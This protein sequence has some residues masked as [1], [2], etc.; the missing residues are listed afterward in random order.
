MYW[1]TSPLFGVWS[2][3][4]KRTLRISCAT[5]IISTGKG[6]D[7]LP[8]ISVDCPPQGAETRW[9][10]STGPEGEK[11]GWSSTGALC[12]TYL[13]SIF[14]I[15]LWCSFWPLCVFVNRFKSFSWKV[16]MENDF[17]R[18]LQGK[19]DLF[20]VSLFLLPGIMLFEDNSLTVWEFTS[21]L[22]C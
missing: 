4:K 1:L 15:L 3:K 2:G 5:F 16:P 7:H 10:S 11:E 8:L 22:L 20:T 21:I 17:L 14:F 12:I 19:L 13:L 9:A 6:L 18:F